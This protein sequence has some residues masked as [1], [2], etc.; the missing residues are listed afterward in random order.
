MAE[1]TPINHEPRP[2]FT[3]SQ[4]SSG[5][6][7]PG[8]HFP[9]HSP[10]KAWC[11]NATMNACA[12]DPQILAVI[13]YLLCLLPKGILTTFKAIQMGNLQ[14]VEHWGAGKQCEL[15]EVIKQHFSIPDPFQRSFYKNQA[16]LRQQKHLPQTR[17]E[18]CLFSAS[19]SV[20]TRWM[21]VF[22]TLP[23][24]QAHY[25]FTNMR[26]LDHFSGFFFTLLSEV[27]Y[28]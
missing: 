9:A 2:P 6:T 14:E 13:S 19:V 17:R 5:D 4:E 24:Q 25:S 23:A 3:P 22:T 7:L 12:S 21:S 27:F 20:A 18:R 11:A 10:L 28:N 15:P 1:P 8:G 26:I 16:S